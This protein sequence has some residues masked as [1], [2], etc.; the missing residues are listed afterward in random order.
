VSRLTTEVEAEIVRLYFAEHWRVG[1]IAT[2]LDVHPDAVRRV[3]GIGG[4]PRSGVPPRVRLVDPYREFIDET[5]ARYPTLRATRL[6]DM[7]RERG[8][9]G[10]VR[11]LRGHVA[12]VRPRRRREVFLRTEPLLG[13]QSQIDWAYVGKLTVPGGER[14][15]WLFVLVLSYS[16]ALW[17]EFVLDLSVHSLCRSLVRAAQA[18][19][20]VTRQWL[21]DNPKTVVLERVGDA[22][23][24]HPVL[25][26][27]C[28]AMRVQPRLC[29]VARPQHK[30]KVERAIRYLRDRFLAGRTIVGV[31]E[32]N[33][34]LG[35]FIGEIAHLRPHP[36]LAQRSVGDVLAE[37]H[38]RLLSLPDPLPETA[39]IE[40]VP[41]DTQAFIRF[42]TNRYAVPTDYAE[43][44]VTLV[45]DD[46]T[47]R[48][49]D[50]DHEIA[51]HA[52]SY[53]RRQ[54]IEPPELRAS[55]VEQRRAAADLKG[56]DRL[57]TVAP[58]FR[59][60]LDRWALTGRSLAIHVTRAIKLL[61]LYGD[62]V[63]AAAVG[64]VCTRGLRDTGALAMACDRLRRDRHRPVPVD[65]VL[66]AHVEDRDVVPHDLETYDD[67]D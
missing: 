63:F 8:F 51:K 23:R 36:V 18:F 48:L 45:A 15:L 33:R 40:P 24:F 35:R 4:G 58:D 2:Q 49:L 30:G 3:L 41:V 67:D 27:L 56:R 38:G 32:G 25:L 14:A 10:A 12:V 44:T 46:R 9:R 66:P 60:L 22:V 43:R 62:E 28:A 21:F 34:A 13:E 20:G 1:T 37:E 17:G 31:D 6:Y 61:D 50:D 59:T 26:E 65:I 64:E 16:R 7:L 19:G 39:R 53:G 55:L 57:L 54:V 29:A 52:R 42:D 5:L 47:V 11:T